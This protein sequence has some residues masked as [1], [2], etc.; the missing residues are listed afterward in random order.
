MSNLTS[1]AEIRQ[2]L[3]ALGFAFEKK[4]EDGSLHWYEKWTYAT[5][6]DFYVYFASTRGDLDLFLTS[7]RLNFTTLPDVWLFAIKGTPVNP[8]ARDAGYQLPILQR[9]MSDIVAFAKTTEA[10]TAL[11][12]A[13]HQVAQLFVGP[14]QSNSSGLPVVPLGVNRL[15]FRA[16]GPGDVDTENL[17]EQ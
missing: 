6:P 15:H 7:V 12:Q 9:Y 16:D 11:K 4:G 5:D 1:L 13:K 17:G 3:D 2:A 14:F 8:R 10:L